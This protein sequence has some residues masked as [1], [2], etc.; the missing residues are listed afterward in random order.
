MRSGNRANG[1]GQCSASQ[2]Y[3][4]LLWHEKTY[5]NPSSKKHGNTK[6]LK[7]G[8]T[9]LPRAPNSQNL[10]FHFCFRQ[11]K[12]L[13]HFN[14]LPICANLLCSVV[15]EVKNAHTLAQVA[16]EISKPYAYLKIGGPKKKWFLTIYIVAR[17][18]Y[19]H[20]FGIPNLRHVYKYLRK[21]SAETTCFL[22]RKHWS[23]MT[24]YLN[25]VHLLEEGLLL[26]LSWRSVDV[27][28]Q[29]F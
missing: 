2:K 13:W 22:K 25:K 3:G 27:R 5:S 6:W 14:H 15:L 28:L 9:Y 17:S 4:N 20:V 19:F 24:F 12:W 23:P 11:G 8:V 21:T 1:G 29:W 10:H 18:N 16:I 26:N 7:I